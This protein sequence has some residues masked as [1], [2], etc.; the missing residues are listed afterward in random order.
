MNSYLTYIKTQLRLTMRDRTVLVFTYLFPLLFFFIFAQTMGGGKGAMIIQVVNMVLVI[1][2][3]GGGFFGGGMRATMEREANILRR[4][5]VAPITPMPIIVSSLVSGL[6]NFLPVAVLVI[7]I[8]HFRYGMPWPE[9]WLSLSVFLIVGSFS[10]RAL[11]MMIASVAN[12]MQESQVI[13]QLLY[14]PM[15]F[16]SG[17][18][19]PLSIM[20]VW[21]QIVAQFLPSTHLYE[22]MQL[23]L[24]K[25]EGLLDNMSKLAALLATTAV[26]MFVSFTL[27]RW[28]KEEKI[29]NSAKAWIMVVMLPFV[30][31]GAYE[32]YT[33][34]SIAKQ[35]S[36]DRDLRR[37]HTRLIKDARVFVGDGTVIERASVL[38]KNG[39]IEDIFLGDAP[40][41]K[42]LNADEEEGAGKTLLP[43]LI[44][45]HVHL[46]APGGYTDK[47]EF[48][49]PLKNVPRRLAAYLFTGVT[50]VRSAGDSIDLMQKQSKLLGSGEQLGTELFYLGPMFTA[51]GGHGT[52]YF[53]MLPEQM[54]QQAMAQTVRTPKTAAEAGEQVAALKPLGVDGIKAI[55][56]SGGGSMTFNRLDTGVYKAIV[57]AA[58][59][60]GLPVSTHTG[61][62]R[63]INDSIE[64]GTTSIEHGTTRQE[65]PAEVF[66]RMK[67]GGIYYDPTLTVY[68]AVAESAAGKTDL[69][70]RSLVMQ[71]G[72]AALI[73][74]SKQ[75][76]QS[77]KLG[78]MSAHSAAITEQ[79]T[80]AKHNL[81]AAYQAGVTLVTGSDA[82]NSTV[83]HGPTVHR[84]VELW[85][86][87]GVPNIAALVGATGNAAKLLGAGNRIGLV[88]KGYEATLLL[89]DGDPTKD[90]GAIERISRVFLK[91]E[92]ID[93]SEIFDDYNK[94]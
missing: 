13:I 72:P 36:V 11:G 7:S 93:R 42:S 61:D 43:G 78:D 50:A 32:G 31:M 22:G 68:E 26:G 23:I 79:F 60:Q 35:K 71:A 28:E 44:D 77:G 83:S 5:K 3:L 65:I 84:E 53:K 73:Q 51:E 46:S 48:Y 37:N 59:A 40:P 76:I 20:P 90:I 92:G 6:V 4:F 12:S 86:D 56:E 55:L 62:L 38:L 33:R 47:P 34:D 29:K 8:A 81:L 24:L 27:F 69:L 67:A 16:L 15:L 75:W 14:F 18:T 70:D 74:S 17:A 1:G 89:V 19:F 9:K 66:A 82:G 63:D 94:K 45:V 91:G 49:D 10:F 21:L 41:A 85:V 57:A 39:K 64:A 25:Q 54:R 88:K 58:K 30:A 2:V 52:E 87:A 80:T